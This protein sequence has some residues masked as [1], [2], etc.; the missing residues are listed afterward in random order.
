LVIIGATPEGRKELVALIDGMRESTESW[1]E[2]LLDLKRRGLTIGPELAVAD[3][4]V[5]N[6]VRGW[7]VQL[8]TPWLQSYA[9]R[10]LICFRRASPGRQGR[11][12]HPRGLVMRE[13]LKLLGS[14]G[15]FGYHRITG[16][17]WKSSKKAD[18]PS[19]IHLPT[20][21]PLE[22]GP[23][24]AVEEIRIRLG[25]TMSEMSSAL[26]LTRQSYSVAINTG[27]VSPV[28]ELAVEGLLRRRERRREFAFV[29]HVADRVP[30]VT[31]VRRPKA[32]NGT[33]APVPDITFLV[34]SQGGEPRVSPLGAL[35]SMVLDGSE[36]FLLPAELLGDPVRD[37]L[38]PGSS[39]AAPSPVPPDRVFPADV[40]K[41]SQRWRHPVPETQHF[42]VINDV[43]AVLG[44]RTQLRVAQILHL[45]ER[46]GMKWFDP[47]LPRARRI[48]QLQAILYSESRQV[49]PK[50]ERVRSGYYR[51]A[52]AT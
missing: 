18:K 41:V 11:P 49:A 50:V 51:E 31:L 40:L 47:T 48:E 27:R 43:L 5:R 30:A 6:F 39:D 37:L 19:C 4:S 20:H 45:L 7:A 21:K 16:H 12:H 23:A 35:P 9:I 29:V 36:Y 2:L 38:K 33:E 34:R 28:L 15:I 10:R 14:P 42:L 26:G 1:R 24:R 25:L 46:A 22:A 32:L 17:H 3:G 13:N 44:G 52:Q 8:T